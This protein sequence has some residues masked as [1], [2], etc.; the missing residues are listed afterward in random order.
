AGEIG[1]RDGRHGAR[2]VDADAA[3]VKRREQFEQAPGAGAQVE[4]RLERPVAD[5]LLQRRLDRAVRRVE[6]AYLV[7]ARGIGAEIVG[8]ALLTLALDGG[9]PFE[10]AL[11]RRV[12]P[13]DAGD[14]AG[15]EIADRLAVGK[16]EEGPR[17]FLI[18]LDQA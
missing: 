5:Q 2:Q 12:A 14:D 11:D 16:T 7:P 8:G 15:E 1:P 9:E 4:H 10:V 18:A 17:A 3:P 6:R 13:V